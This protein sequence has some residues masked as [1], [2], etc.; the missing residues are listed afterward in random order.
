MM[1]WRR[2]YSPSGSGIWGAERGDMMTVAGPVGWRAGA[3]LNLPDRAWRGGAGPGTGGVSVITYNGERIWD[4]KAD[5]GFPDAKT[6][7][8]RVPN[9]P[10]RDLGPIDRAAAGKEPE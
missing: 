9:H 6:L 5:G 2:A 10:G 8:Q 3:A 1:A 7:K 4:P